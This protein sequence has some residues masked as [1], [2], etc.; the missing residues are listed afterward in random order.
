MIQTS[1]SMASKC[2][3]FVPSS[4]YDVLPRASSLEVHQTLRWYN[5]HTHLEAMVQ[6]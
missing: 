1:C 2:V 6:L 4:G 3:W 5:N